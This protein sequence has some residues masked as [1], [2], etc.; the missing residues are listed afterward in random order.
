MIK[1]QVNDLISAFNNLQERTAG[2]FDGVSSEDIAKLA[3]VLSSGE[4]DENKIV[5][6][7][8]NHTK[9]N[10]SVDESDA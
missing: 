6:A 9:P 2:M 10:E 7:Y 4:L 3:D 8:I 1:R 5:E